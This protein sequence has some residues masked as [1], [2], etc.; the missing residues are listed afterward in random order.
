MRR[1]FTFIELLIV[2]GII[3]ILAAIL[4]PVFAKAREKA[5]QSSCLSNLKQIGVGLAH[6]ASDFD[7][8]M[9]PMPLVSPSQ[10]NTRSAVV[11]Q[12]LNDRGDVRYP[13]FACPSDPRTKGLAMIA[14]PSYALRDEAFG[15]LILQKG[16][17][18]Y[19]VVADYAGNVGI[20]S[21]ESLDSLADRHNDGL[22]VLFL[23]G[24]AKWHR[25]DA[26][27]FKVEGGEYRAS[28]T[29][30]PLRAKPTVRKL[31]RQPN[32]T[33]IDPE[34]KQVFSLSSD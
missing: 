34:T 23:D 14:S 25:A 5:R 2:I 26:F 3:A 29:G 10:V 6:Y 11:W 7:G 18:S 1:G 17:D 28:L 24:H 30:R 19:P 22:N 20:W 21:K 9:P 31:I 32:G 13:C 27:T 12:M 33:Y 8:A 15:L 4:F 16:A